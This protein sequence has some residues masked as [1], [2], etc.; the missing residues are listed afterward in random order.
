[1]PLSNSPTHWDGP[2]FDVEKCRENEMNDMP[3]ASAQHIIERFMQA[4][5]SGDWQGGETWIDAGEPLRSCQHG[6]G[7]GPL[8]FAALLAPDAVGY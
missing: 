4:W 3:H 8:A 1:M 6:Q 5:R 7:L 2:D